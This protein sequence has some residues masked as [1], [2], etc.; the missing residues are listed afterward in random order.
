MK[1]VTTEY[2]PSKQFKIKHIEEGTK[3][4]WIG[5]FSINGWV[6]IDK[7]VRKGGSFT[8]QSIEPNQIYQPLTYQHNRFL[9]CGYSF[10]PLSDG[11]VHYFIP[12]LKQTTSETL[13]RKHPITSYWKRRMQEMD[14]V[15]FFGSNSIHG[16]D[17][18]LFCTSHTD[19]VFSR[20]RLHSI[21]CHHTFR[22]LWIY[23]PQDKRLNIAE[24]EVV[25]RRTKQKLPLV[26]T[27]DTPK[28]MGGLYD[29]DIVKATDG[30]NITR[31]ES[32]SL[33][34]PCV[35]D[36]EKLH[37]IASI[38]YVPCN[39][40]NYIHPGQTYELFYQNGAE[41]WKSLGCQTA[42]SNHLLYKGIPRNALL[43][44]HNHTTGVEEQVFLMKDGRQ[45]F[46]Y[47]SD[48]ALCK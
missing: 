24:I 29:Y 43:W 41:G 16:E 22:Y 1:D 6:P 3:E 11:T 13:Y 5:V 18:V 2:Y 45:W 21:D 38:L 19:S 34:V 36:L 25:D 7:L 30:A 47:I 48:S 4:A 37:E 33:S 10:M 39:D 17:K 20:E 46:R 28:P 15:T 44:L 31:Y 27:P 14:G 35:F 40:D 42:S 9:P 23:P 12:N 26:S 8:L 32:G